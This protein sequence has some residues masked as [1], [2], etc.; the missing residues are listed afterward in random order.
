[1]QLA[2]QKSAAKEKPSVCLLTAFNS[3]HQPLSVFTVP[4]MRAFAL[5]HDYSVRV[6]C[7]DD[8]ERQRGWIKIEAIREALDGDF[9]FVFWLDV[10]AV[11]LRSEVDVRTMAVENA[12]LHMVWHGPETSTV[13]AANFVPHFNSGIMLIRGTDWS[14]RF[15]KRVW[16]VGQLPHHWSDQAT[17]LHLLGYDD[18]LGLGP[19]RP[20]EPNRLHLAR[21]DT[22]WNSVPGLATAPDAIIHHYAGISNPSSR[23]R[24]VELD[25]RTALLREGAS[26][27]LRQAFA[28]QLSRW[29]ED[30]TMRDWVTNERDFA[31][32]ELQTVMAERNGILA[33]RDAAWAAVLAMRNSNSWRVTGPL[34]WVSKALRRLRK[35]D[36]EQAPG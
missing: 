30:A 34:R 13:E 23:L 15:F 35:Q 27:Q 33:E 2:R 21:L 26:T 36:Q 3:S 10:D 20:D 29:R 12:D 32:A 5:A 4:R 31:L 1:M 8:C 28:E 25:A 24:L 11:I 9:D 7:K 16:E 22:V 14:R 18:C 17:M 19:N 6:V